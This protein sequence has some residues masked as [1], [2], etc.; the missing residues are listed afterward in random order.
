MQDKVYRQ[1]TSLVDT[2]GSMYPK[3][4]LFLLTLTLFIHLS[5]QL[6]NLS[7]VVDLTRMIYEDE[8]A[9]KHKFVLFY[10]GR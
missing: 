5:I 3:G 9:N 1:Y 4:R 2:M 8:L 7:N 10:G 6:D